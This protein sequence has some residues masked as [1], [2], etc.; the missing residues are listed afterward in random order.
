MKALFGVVIA[1]QST[2]LVLAQPPSK[3]PVTAPRSP[4]YPA[5]VGQTSDPALEQLAKDYETAFNQGDAKALAGLYEMNALRVTPTGQLLTGRASIEE[6]Y[7][8]S[9]AGPLKGTK[10]TLHP[11][12]TQP[13]TPDVALIEGTYE[14]TDGTTSVKGRYLNTAT[15][16]SGRWRLASVV[17]VPEQP[18]AAR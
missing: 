7:L 8:T 4:T 5:P 3:P 9:L 16:Q 10:L 15:R 14:V 13:L 1:L 6:D 2:T 18:A 12:K 17:T 11:G